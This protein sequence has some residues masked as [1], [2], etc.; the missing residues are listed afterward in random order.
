M[1][2]QERHFPVCNLNSS[3]LV[4]MLVCIFDSFKHSYLWLFS[5]AEQLDFRLVKNRIYHERHGSV[6][7]RCEKTSLRGFRPGLT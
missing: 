4:H 3:C 1:V 7:P 6:E 2:E 5:E